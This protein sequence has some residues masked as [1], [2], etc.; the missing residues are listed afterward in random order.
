MNSTKLRHLRIPIF[1]IL[2]ILGLSTGLSAQRDTSYKITGMKVVNYN[3]YD[4]IFK[5][6]SD[7]VD[8]EYWNALGTSVIVSVVV[9]AKRD[10][11]VPGRKVEVKVY[12]GKKL[13]QTHNGNVGY[14]R[15]GTYYVPTM[16]YG[17]FCQP[18]TIKAR[19]TGQ[20]QVSIISKT[21]NFA[22]GE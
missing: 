17:P 18:L 6:I 21:L 13:I 10:T 5:D 19:I 14:I 12:E 8:F 9:S 20:R 3:Q 7:E 4:H 16:L 22:C 11:Y 15:S 2:S 1:V